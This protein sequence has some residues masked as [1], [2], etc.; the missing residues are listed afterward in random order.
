[1][2]DEVWFY[3]TL[4]LSTVV[5]ALL[6]LLIM[7][8]EKKLL[9]EEPLKPSR[10]KLREMWPLATTRTIS[11]DVV[12]NAKDKLR[13]LDLER[14]I[15]SYAIR[16]LYEAQ[17]EGKITEEE[18]DSLSLK[19][20]DDL[21]RIKEEISRGE[22][23]IALNELER[24]QQEFVDLFSERFEALSRRIEELRA[25]SGFQPPKIE[26]L[27]TVE[28][29]EGEEKA[30]APPQPAEKAV[31][32]KRKKEAAKPKTPSEEA[33]TEKSEAEKKAEQILAE[34]E[35]VLEKLGQMEVE[36]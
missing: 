2:A 32:V 24:M 35:K 13:I 12:K 11:E 1:M 21:N 26:P 4:M 5:I 10:S 36:E 18:R 25:I 34:V 30:A 20:K 17:A 19:Y 31:P 33:K 27:E 29:I 14:E 23:I 28:S 8:R 15:L 9:R 6:I 7:Q 3:I 16:R 22:S